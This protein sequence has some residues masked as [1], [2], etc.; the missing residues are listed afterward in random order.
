MQ[1]AINII[2]GL[3]A[4]ERAVHYLRS[5]LAA[6]ARR[7][8]E[9]RRLCLTRARIGIARLRDAAPAAQP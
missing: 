2:V 8:A 5:A 4:I 1:T 7:R 6:I 9:Q 3:L